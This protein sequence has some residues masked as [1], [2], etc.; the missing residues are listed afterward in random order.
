MPLA[1]VI[2]RQFLRHQPEHGSI[3]E[4]EQRAAAGEDQQR[5]AP[6]QCAP[7]RGARPTSRVFWRQTTGDRVVDGLLGHR[8]RCHHA[9]YGRR[10]HHPEQHRRAEEGGGGQDHQ[11]YRGVAGMEQGLVA[12]SAAGEPL[13]AN[14]AE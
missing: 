12:A 2:K 3:S 6:K 4:V 9:T 10:A 1:D 13:W 8:R 5:T 14:N 11:I 7:H